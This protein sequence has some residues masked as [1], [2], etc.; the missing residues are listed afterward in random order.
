M[1]VFEITPVVL[2]GRPSDPDNKVLI[3]RE[4]HI[5]AVNYWNGVIRGL[6]QVRTLNGNT[7][8]AN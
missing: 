8:I 7:S 5:K 6:R 4:Q 1:E 2:G 3:T